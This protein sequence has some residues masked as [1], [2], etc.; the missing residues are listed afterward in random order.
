MKTIYIVW[1]SPVSK[2]L[3]TEQVLASDLETGLAVW[4]MKYPALNPADI[5]AVYDGGQA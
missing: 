3:R 2:E 5:S 1:R 4:R